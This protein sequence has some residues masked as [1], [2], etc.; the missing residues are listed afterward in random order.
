MLLESNLPLT[1][2]SFAVVQANFLYN[3]TPHSAL[4]QKTPFLMRYGLS[5]NYERMIP[6]GCRIEIYIKKEKRSKLDNTTKPGIMLGYSN[7]STELIALD[8]N[9]ANIE[10][11]PSTSTI[12]PKEFPG[13]PEDT[14]REFLLKQEDMSSMNDGNNYEI[15]TSKEEISYD[16]QVYFTKEEPIPNSIYEA[17]KMQDS[18]KWMSAVNDELKNLNNFD[19]YE[20]VKLPKDH[21]TVTTRFVFTK[22][23]SEK[24]N[25]L[26]YKA[27]LV[28]GFEF[29]TNFGDTFSPTPHL[30]SLR[31][32]VSY[33]S[34]MNS[35]GYSL[36]SID[37]VSAF[38]NGINDPHV[39]VTPPK[40][41]SIK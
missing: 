40:G 14:L 8:F 36:F 18:N 22:K 1:F 12:K 31:F 32:I 7:N 17:S 27:R 26:R 2:W 29:K 35:G 15:V 33:C 34:S 4:D 25:S 20:I 41:V 23:Y 28:R 9:S 13:I 3:R 21:Q 6:F 30:D 38:L 5:E 39:Y 19:A 24:T 10:I 11:V 37:F 16:H